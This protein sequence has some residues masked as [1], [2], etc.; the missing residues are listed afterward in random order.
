MNLAV[1]GGTAAVALLN[2]AA[3]SSDIRARTIPNA[4]VISGAGIAL[5]WRWMGGLSV[6][7]GAFGLGAGLG[8][9]LGLFA[10]RVLGAGDGKLIAA[11]GAFLGWSHLG[12]ALLATGLAGGLLGLMTALYQG[13]FRKA[14]AGA[15]YAMVYVVTL[16]RL[17]ALPAPREAGEKG[18]PY[19]VAIAAG[20]LATWAW[21]YL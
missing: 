7:D 18:L 2:A 16:G 5:V 21:R 9:G 10:L 13:R 19:G 15:G 11:N 8:I 4:L 20:A 6:T 14:L 3:V 17:G 12:T 1:L